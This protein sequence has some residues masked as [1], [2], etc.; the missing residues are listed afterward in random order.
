[1]IP[2]YLDDKFPERR[3]LPTDPYKKFQQKL[4]AEQL[5]VLGPAFYGMM[6]AFKVGDRRQIWE[7]SLFRTPPCLRRKTPW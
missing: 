5:G 6:A 2:E 7:T 1:M 4:F 3:I